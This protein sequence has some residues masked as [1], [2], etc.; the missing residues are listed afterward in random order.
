[1]QHHS[2]SESLPGGGSLAVHQCGHGLIHVRV[3]RVTVTLRPEEFH[4]LALLVSE[5]HIRLRTREIVQEYSAH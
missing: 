5:T 1:M 3:G 4:R 2:A